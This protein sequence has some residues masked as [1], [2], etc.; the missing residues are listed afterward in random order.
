MSVAASVH[1]ALASLLAGGTTAAAAGAVV[2]AAAASAGFLRL[3]IAAL[4]PAAHGGRRA[5]HSVLPVAGAV[6]SV[7]PANTSGCCSAAVAF[8]YFPLE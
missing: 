1:L 5:L 2:V 6:T 8:V 7:K 4:A 3:M